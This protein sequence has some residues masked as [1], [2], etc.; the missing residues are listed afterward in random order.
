MRVADDLFFGNG[1]CDLQRH[2]RCRQQTHRLDNR[3]RGTAIKSPHH[4]EPADLGGDH[5]E[6]EERR[7]VHET[8]VA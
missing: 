5:E 2:H 8:D 6:R 4:G 1:L 3:L 7:L